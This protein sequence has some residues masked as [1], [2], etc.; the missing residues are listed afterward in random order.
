[1]R[2]ERWKGAPLTA[3]PLAASRMLARAAS[4]PDELFEGKEVALRELVL[5]ADKVISWS[6]TIGAGACL[7]TTLGAEGE[8]A[9]IEARVFDAEEGEID[10]SE[11]A[12]AVS[13]RACAGGDAPRTVKL[14]VSASAGRLDAVL[15]E[16]LGPGL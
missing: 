8:G 15:G 12:H 3:H 11:D 14:E 6:E 13:V 2:P 5:E 10:R 1:V 16:R 4:G 9:G 7:R